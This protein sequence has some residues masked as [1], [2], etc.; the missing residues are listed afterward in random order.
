ML[1]I[2][3][4]SSSWPLTK[5]SESIDSFQNWPKTGNQNV[6]FLCKEGAIFAHSL[7][8]S[9]NN[10]GCHAFKEEREKVLETFFWF[11]VAWSS[12][13]PG[14]THQVRRAGSPWP[15]LL[16]QYSQSSSSVE[17]S[18][19]RRKKEEWRMNQSK[20]HHTSIVQQKLGSIIRS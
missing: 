15:A 17:P 11:S 3:R 12:K 2:I 1:L 10:V 19:E 7:M 4:I 6:M 16:V 8:L 5:R 9:F 14:K 18:L 13:T 20:N